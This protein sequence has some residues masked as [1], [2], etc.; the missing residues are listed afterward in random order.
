MTR[1]ESKLEILKKVENG[2]LS[3]EEGSALLG[4]FDNAERQPVE[5]EI[6]KMTMMR[7]LPNPLKLLRYPAAGRLPGA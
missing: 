1:E 5:P 2:V 6:V 7:N 3:V 4:I